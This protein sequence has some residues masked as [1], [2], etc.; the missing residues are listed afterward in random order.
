MRGKGDVSV[1]C[2]CVPLLVSRESMRT[3]KKNGCF[4]AKV[5][6]GGIE[7][8][9]VSKTVPYYNVHVDTKKCVGRQESENES[10]EKG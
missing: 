3:K 5:T 6:M 10:E 9:A 8:K 1:Y 2:E 4:V 7:Y